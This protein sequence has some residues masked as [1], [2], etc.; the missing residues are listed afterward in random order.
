MSVLKPWMVVGACLGLWG[1][2]DA[3]M[4][5]AAAQDAPP[6]PAASA[7]APV[8]PTPEADPAQPEDGPTGAQR[9]EPRPDPDPRIEADTGR[10]V[11]IWPPDVLFD[12]IHM[13]L[14]M[15]I[16]DMTK[17]QFSAVETLKVAPIGVA[18]SSIILDAGPG[19]SI[20]EIQVDGK[21]VFF[22]H[23]AQTQKL[24]IDF[25][26]PVPAGHP[27]TIRMT[28]T[29][30]TP[31]GGGDGLT[32]SGDDSRTPEVDWAMHAQ[33]EPQHNHLWFPCH[34]FPNERLSTEISVTVPQ[35]YEAVS[36]GRLVGVT[37]SAGRPAPETLPDGAAPS[38][39]PIATATYHWRQDKTHANYLVT[40]VVSRFEVV[41]VGG[42]QSDFPG[43]WMPVY[44]PL[45]AGEALRQGFG[46][47]PAMIK[48]FSTLF[49]FP[50]PWDKY[51]QVMCR[52]FSAGAM[53]NTSCT[54]FNGSMARGGRRGSLDGIIAHELV[55]Q[56][57]GD[58]VTCK[59]WEHIWL[60]EGWATLGEALWAEHVDGEDGYQAAIL[61]NF[62]A[63]R[64]RSATRYAPR[65]PAMVSNRYRSPDSKFTSADN[66]YSKGGSI[67]HMLRMRLGDDLFWAGTRLYL[68]RHQYSNA[69]TDDFRLALEEVSGQSLERFFDQWCRR[70][71]M[72]T[73][74][75]DYEWA[76]DPNADGAGTLQVTLEQ[77]Q[78]I[79][80]DNPAYAVQLPLSARMPDDLPTEHLF[81]LCDARSTRA[82]FR[83]KAKPVSI[84]VDPWLTV[85]C[86]HRVRQPLA[87]NIDQYHNG[88]TMASRLFALEQIAED[89]APESLPVLWRAAAE[90]G[91]TAAMS[92]AGLHA[93]RMLLAAARRGLISTAI[94][95]PA[96]ATRTFAT[97]GDSILRGWGAVIAEA[98]GRTESRELSLSPVR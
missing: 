60:N 48:H 84:G 78:K 29:A 44:G 68:K 33:G 70:P 32:W 3:E 6:D 47:T 7:P 20:S 16:P 52:N 61:G 50:F 51:A 83:L 22:R 23:D 90:L 10:D 88:P 46:N 80:A 1:L 35:P 24:T 82:S 34:D 25:V 54:T 59:S 64:A 75:I 72:P 11:R 30:D 58:L 39:G 37:R 93:N 87:A 14:D 91:R 57:F 73:F 31:G 65:H 2:P 15:T 66:A 49:D 67:L 71:G 62:G 45:G 36:N 38:E 76:P 63:E 92:E 94:R 85:L 55:H 53:E 43:L 89:A 69:E 28:Y 17:K 41:N 18:R 77:T 13:R 42:P 74:A 95:L 81:A 97:L 4:G 8:T 5:L 19:L 56:W 86:R 21:P 40:L 98:D 79:D 12:H 9:T 96:Q 26:D 27:A